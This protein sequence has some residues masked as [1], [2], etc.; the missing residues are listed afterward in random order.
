MVIKVSKLR[1]KV[2]KQAQSWVGLKESNGTHCE[3]IDIYN[4]HKPLARGYEMKYKDAW[5]SCFVSAVAIKLGYTDIIPTEVSC[6]KHIELFKKKNEW[7]ESDS[8]VPKPGDIIFYYWKDNGVGDCTKGASHVG[9]VEKVSNRVITIIE[10]NLNNSVARREIKVNA[11]Y[12]RGYGVPKYDEEHSEVVPKPSEPVKYHIVKKGE[13]LSKIA[14]KYKTTYIKIYNA[15]KTL[16]DKEN[17]KRGVN[18]SK[19]WVY[20]GQKLVIK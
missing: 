8:Y 10:G 6:G 4:S 12:I 2:V 14:K 5:C 11:R 3:I 13:N 7:V 20:P 9:I 1:K 19:M 15:N 16:I 17:K 18:T